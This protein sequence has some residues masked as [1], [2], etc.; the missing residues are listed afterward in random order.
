MPIQ[1][2]PITALAVTL[3]MTVSSGFY[4]RSLIHDLGIE[5]GSYAY[6]N[7]LVRTRQGDWRLGEN[8]L[9]WEFFE[10]EDWNKLLVLV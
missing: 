9:E 4:V 2:P 7:S 5:L 3:R 1:G 10:Q 8:V 6:M